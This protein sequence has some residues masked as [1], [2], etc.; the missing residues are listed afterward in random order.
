MEYNI[1]V[2]NGPTVQKFKSWSKLVDWWFVV[3]GQIICFAVLEHLQNFFVRLVIN[4]TD[5]TWNSYLVIAKGSKYYWATYI[6]LFI[7][8]CIHFQQSE[9]QFV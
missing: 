5:R 1:V 8:T 4:V 3:K 6:I 7:H 9:C 2:L